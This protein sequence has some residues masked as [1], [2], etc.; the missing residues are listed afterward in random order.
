[1]EV[2]QVIIGGRGKYKVGHAIAGSSYLIY[3]DNCPL[4]NQ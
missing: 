2:S 4:F 1:M 3:V